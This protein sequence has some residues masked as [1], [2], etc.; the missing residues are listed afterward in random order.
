LPTKCSPAKDDYFNTF[1]GN[2]VSCAA[3]LAVLDVLEEENLQQNALEVGQTLVDGLRSLMEKHAAIG[4]VRGS[5]FFIGLELV[6]D[7]D[8]KTPA[9]ALTKR[10]V[11][12][13]R[14][15]GLLTGSIGPDANILKLRCPM[16]LS[17]DDADYALEIIDASLATIGS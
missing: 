6:D 7:R 11:N 12:D 15:R 5:G 13:L 2:P 1:G 4:D 14:N 17:R 3:G 10:V 8:Q 16:V 9:T